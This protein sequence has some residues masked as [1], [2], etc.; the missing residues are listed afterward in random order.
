VDARDQ[1]AIQRRLA[2]LLI[3]YVIREHTYQKELAEQQ[4][5]SRSQS[6]HG[7]GQQHTR[8]GSR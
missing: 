1:R 2:A 6:D 3:G 5:S 7:P 8:G 4:Q